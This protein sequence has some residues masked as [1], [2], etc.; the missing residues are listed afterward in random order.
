MNLNG[1]VKLY[2]SSSKDCH[3]VTRRKLTKL[4]N[5]AMTID[6]PCMRE[7][8]NMPIDEGVEDVFSDMEKLAIQYRFSGYQRQTRPSVTVLHG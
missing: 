4:I 3:C 1:P 7:F 8:G 5:A 2:V 6:T